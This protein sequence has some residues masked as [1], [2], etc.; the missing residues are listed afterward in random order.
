MSSNQTVQAN[1]VVTIR[2]RLDDAKGTPLQSK[3]EEVAYLHGGYD[4]LLPKIEAAL[5]GQPIG[6]STTVDLP[7]QDG[8]GERDESLVR[9][10]N[11]SEL[12][13]GTKVGGQLQS[14]DAQGQERVFRV[15]KIKGTEVQL[16]GN[17]PLA[18]QHVRFVVRVLGLRPATPEEIQHGHAH[19]EHGH[20]H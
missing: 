19:G 16:D 6:Y 12:P 8:F 9:T 15:L 3:A 17:H 11:K 1:S 13:A 18:G 20:H 4:N 7:A 14:T 5:E 10:I 2:Y